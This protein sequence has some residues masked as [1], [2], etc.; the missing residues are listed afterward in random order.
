MIGISIYIVV[1]MLVCVFHDNPE[2][3]SKEDETIQVL[4]LVALLFLWPFYVATLFVRRGY[5]WE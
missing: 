1:G 2:Q 4:L 5:W 3:M